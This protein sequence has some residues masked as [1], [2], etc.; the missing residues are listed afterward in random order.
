[1]L[2]WIG[3]LRSGL[4]FLRPSSSTL[5]PNAIVS[6]AEIGEQKTTIAKLKTEIAT[7]WG[8]IEEIEM[9]MDEL[10]AEDAKKMYRPFGKQYDQRILDK[11]LEP[12][13][14]Q[15]QELLRAVTHYQEILAEADSWLASQAGERR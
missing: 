14:S 2:S 15:Q 11:K 9:Q 4:D 13:R 12:L 10:K 5:T 3:R 6:E 7:L 8:K 1:M